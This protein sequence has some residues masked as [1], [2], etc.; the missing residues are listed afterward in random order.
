MA[1]VCAAPGDWPEPRQNPGLTGVQP[2]SGAMA[3][4]P[5]VT[6]TA[7]LGRSAP[8]I[9]EVEMA[10]GNNAGL[11]LHAGTLYCYSQAGDTMWRAH[12]EGLN[13]TSIARVDDLDAD[14][15]TEILMQAGR[16]AEPFGAAVL[17]GLEDGRV[18]WRYDVE[19]MSYVWYLSAGE[20]LPQSGHKQI[21]VLMQGYPP[22][23]K[24]GYIALFEFAEQAPA[25]VQRWRYDFDAYTCF[26]T[27]LQSDVDGDGAKELAVQTHSRM[28]LLDS[29]TGKLKQ[30]VSWDV[31]PANVR[32]YG[33]VEF[34]DI[35]R[36]GLDDF[37]CIANFAQHHEVLL[38][39]RG[40]LEKAWSH[41]WDESVTTGKVATAYPSP[42]VGDVDADGTLEVV[43][44]MFNSEGE[45][46]WLLRIYDSL[47]GTLKYT[48]EGAV[49]RTLADIDGDGTFE[50]LADLTSDPSSTAIDSAALFGVRDGRLVERWAQEGARVAPG[51]EITDAVVQTRSGQFRLTGGI[52]GVALAAIVGQPTP[53]RVVI[54]PPAIVGPNYGE[55]VAVDYDS[56]GINEVGLYQ[57]PAMRFFKKEGDRLVESARYTSACL[58]V[59]ADI[60]GDT[61]NDLITVDV[62][63][64]RLPVVD[65]VTP[66]NTNALL[67]RTQMPETT[68]GGVSQPRDAYL[69]TGH[70]TGRSHPDLYLWAGTPVGRSIVLNGATGAM[71]WERG[72]VESGIGRFLGAT[73][74]LASVSDEDG[75][76]A[77]D[78][79]MT[80][81]DYYVVLDGKTG[82]YRLGPLFPPTI[83][84]Q[85]SQGL[86]TF[87]AILSGP[88]D[89]PTVALVAGHYFQGIM[90]L[91]AEPA[92][93]V[94][95]GAGDARCAVEGFIEVGPAQWRMGFGRQNG[96][97][98]C[99][100][101]SDGSIRW[102]FPLD[103]AAGDTITCDVDGDQRPEFVVASTHGT[104]YALGDGGHAPRVVWTKTLGAACGPPIAADVD[105]D[106]LSEIIVQTADGYLLAL[107]AP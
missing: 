75:D 48:M 1:A 38:N 8:S 80:I 73:T 30:F 17:V 94:I 25:P 3:T 46:D 4:S 70:F 37:L 22:D 50:I 62:S 19:P 85:P 100:D 66:A 87:P 71:I 101:I 21:V 76:G 13:F 59:V 2:M 24:N 89:V 72:E 14:G 88:G 44:S 53:N 54:A 10:D 83:F 41:G 91:R 35:N 28:W 33:L 106:G 78:L 45:G 31:A 23:A 56:D 16:P 105:G 98:S 97:F 47:T 18:Q 92:W 5:R 51:S 34:R 107:G 12:P 42:A 39:K 32:S 43:L 27:L 65:A 79:V 58:P 77:D 95:P 67:W 15:D 90:S 103:G 104:L 63:P 11:A 93:Y 86:Y 74:N 84:G 52:D 40:T 57:D 69:R 26:P 36:D 9:R 64:V 61:M 102:E 29:G 7:D 60:D 82:N 55:L 96:T 68:G 20:Y 49:A 99:V 6:A 81:P